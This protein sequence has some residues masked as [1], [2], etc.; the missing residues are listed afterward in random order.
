M[1]TVDQHP[2]I[3]RDRRDA[4]RALSERL[5]PLV[6]ERPLVLGLPRGGVVLAAEVAGALRAPLDVVVARKVGAPGNPEY[7]IGAVAEGGVAV[8]HDDAIAELGVSS[9]A[10]AQALAR[11]TRELEDAVRCYRAGAAPAP[12]TDRTAI[13]VDDGLATGSTA[14]AAVRSVRRRG[15]A[16]VVLAVPVCSPA[17][18][19]LLMREVDEL[20]CVERPALFFAIGC[21]YADFASTTDEE[22]VAALRPPPAPPA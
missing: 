17:G 6:G 10:L 9:E 4:G 2:R 14:Q 18:A 11:A 12:L 3:F 13:V 16:R 5:C 15:A 19:E 1:A 8:L 20:I 7:G 21:W 22:V